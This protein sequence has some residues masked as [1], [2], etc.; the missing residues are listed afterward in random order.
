MILGILQQ[1]TISPIS[2]E[3]FR[4]SGL[5]G[6]LSLKNRIHPG[7]HFPPYKGE[8]NLFLLKKIYPLTEIL[9]LLH[10]KKLWERLTNL[11]HQQCPQK[12]FPSTWTLAVPWASWI[13]RF[14]VFSNLGKFWSCFFNYFVVFPSLS[15]PSGTPSA[16]IEVHVKLSHSL[17]MLSSFY[18]QT[19]SLCVSFCY[20]KFINLSSCGV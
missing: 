5:W 13:C 18:C 9:L 10:R 17:L 15:S 3:Y 11:V 4:H 1:S 7:C 20:V 16:Y 12:L 2:S 19:P 14:I 6:Q 8:L